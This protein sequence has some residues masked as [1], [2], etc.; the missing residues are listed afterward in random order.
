MDLKGP[1][2]NRESVLWSE[3][4]LVYVELRGRA[5]WQLNIIINGVKE[6]MAGI[7][8]EIGEEDL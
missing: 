2:W 1:D 6:A 4:G 5:G 8:K 3:S 7:M